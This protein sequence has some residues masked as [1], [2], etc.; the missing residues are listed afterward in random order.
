M[1]HGRACPEGERKADPHLT[2]G[3]GNGGFKE[4]GF[5]PPNSQSGRYPQKFRVKVQKGVGYVRGLIVTEVCPFFLAPSCQQNQSLTSHHGGDAQEHVEEEE[6][7]AAI[8]P[9][10]RRGDSYGMRRSVP[11]AATGPRRPAVVACGREVG[12]G[13]RIQLARPSG[14]RAQFPPVRRGS[15]QASV[16][17]VPHVPYS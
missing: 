7:K 15:R 10:A 2:S 13:R 12:V 11:L 14:G 6:G 1:S 3:E 8:I 17:A 5:R 4:N 9:W 16:V